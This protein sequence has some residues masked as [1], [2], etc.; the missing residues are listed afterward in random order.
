MSRRR[1][2]R[3]LPGGVARRWSAS[4]GVTTSKSCRAAS[5]AASARR[6]GAPLSGYDSHA[7][8]PSRIT[9]TTSSAS[10]AAAADREQARDEVGG[11]VGGIPRRVREADPVREDPVAEEDGGR[12]DARETPRAE[13]RARAI[14]LAEAQAG[15]QRLQEDGLVRRR[16]LDAGLSEQRERAF[17][18]R[19]LGRPHAARAEAEVLF[20]RPEAERELRP[21]VVGVREARRRNG[22]VGTRFAAPRSSP[23]GA[24]GSDGGRGSSRPRRDPTRRRASRRGSRPRGTPPDGPEARSSPSR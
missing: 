5:A 10:G 14:A 1:R 18:E 19:P 20:E 3:G 7:F 17:R 8:S 23:A 12:R 15:R 22:Q 13:H 2:V 9:G 16:P 11:G 4:V 6:N 24:A 21:R